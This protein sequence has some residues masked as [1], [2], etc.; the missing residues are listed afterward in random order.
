VVCIPHCALA[1]KAC[2]STH[3]SVALQILSAP[4]VEDTMERVTGGYRVVVF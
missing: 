4:E 3:T 1:G 2:A